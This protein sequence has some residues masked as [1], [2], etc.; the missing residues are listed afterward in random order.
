FS[1]LDVVGEELGVQAVDRVAGDIGG[2]DDNLGVE[3]EPVAGGVLGDDLVGL[4]QLGD[5]LFFGAGSFAVGDQLDDVGVVIAPIEVRVAV[6]D[7]IAVVDV[8]LQ[9]RLEVL[10]LVDLGVPL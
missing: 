4:G 8:L 5:L 6:E 2:R 1:L 9:R 7:D 10:L 3:V